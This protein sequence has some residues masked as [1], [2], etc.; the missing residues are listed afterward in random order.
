MLKLL[1]ENL[2]FLANSDLL[3][4]NYLELQNGDARD[5]QKKLLGCFLLSLDFLKCGLVTY[6]LYDILKR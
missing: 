6:F 4:Q 2:N 3:N 1:L 5:D